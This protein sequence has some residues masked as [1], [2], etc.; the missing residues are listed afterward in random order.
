MEYEFYDGTHS[1][2][3][4][5]EGVGA[6][7]APD[8]TPTDGSSALI[9][10]GAVY[11]AVQNEATRADSKIQ[12]MISASNPSKIASTLLA[13]NWSAGEYSFESTYP[14]DEYDLTVEVSDQA[15]AG[16]Y[17]AFVA[18]NIVGSLDNIIK[19]LG[20]VPTVDIPIILTI[21]F[22]GDLNG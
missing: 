4:L 20:T 14:A 5:D 15:T 22:T 6:A 13:A 19:A 12:Q 17:D 10:S 7:L 8:T 3:Q 21:R 1:G 18:G 2:Q 11:T 16:Q 9:T